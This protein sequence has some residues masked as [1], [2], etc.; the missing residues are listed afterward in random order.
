MN[1]FSKS[2][3]SPWLTE[4]DQ[5]IHSVHTIRRLHDTGSNVL[6]KMPSVK[7]CWVLAYKKKAGYLLSEVEHV[8]AVLEWQ[9]MD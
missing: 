8:Q 7:R 5:M 9:E 6:V 4:Q 3:K 2:T 1:I